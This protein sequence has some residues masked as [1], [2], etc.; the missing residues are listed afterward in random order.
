MSVFQ[1]RPICHPELVSG[2]SKFSIL[3]DAESILK[4]VQHKVQ[5]D[6]FFGFRL[7]TNS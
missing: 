3:L 6:I 4:R 5:H 1:K 7:F 2:S